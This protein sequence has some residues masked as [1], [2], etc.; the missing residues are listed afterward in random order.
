MLDWKAFIS[1]TL[2]RINQT[3]LFVS[4]RYDMSP[5]KWIHLRKISYF[6]FCLFELEVQMV[7]TKCKPHDFMLWWNIILSL[8]MQL[9]YQFMPAWNSLMWPTELRSNVPTRLFWSERTGTSQSTHEYDDA[10]LKY[11]NKN[12][13]ISALP[14]P[15]VK[16]MNN[17]I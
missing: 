10:T 15:V 12:Y 4:K 9:F 6:L 7:S 17:P 16:M 11:R 3:C 2:S 13:G 14:L 5:V 8:L 1:L